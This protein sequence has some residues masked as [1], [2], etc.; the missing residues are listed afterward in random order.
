MFRFIA[1]S[2]LSLCLASPLA[3]AGSDNAKFE[4]KQLDKSLPQVSLS[5]S[6]PGDYAE[7]TLTIKEDQHS[8]TLT[9]AKDQIYVIDGFSSNAFSLVA[10]GHDQRELKLF[11]LPGSFKVKETDESTYAEF[12]AMLQIAPKPS[13]QGASITYD[14]FLRD[15]TMHCTYDYS[16]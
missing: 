11:G 3:L 5:G 13:Y 2:A 6:I 15:I 14:S 8:L 7:F 1:I 10:V 4:C 16:I 12:R 9:D